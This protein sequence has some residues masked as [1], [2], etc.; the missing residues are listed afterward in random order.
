MKQED[1][2]GFI[3]LILAVAILI[4][5]VIVGINYAKEFMNKESVKDLQA[6]L[7]LIQNKVEILKGNNDMNSDENPLRGYQ[8]SQLPEGTDIN[9]FLEK[10]VITQEE[11]EKYYLL[12]SRKF[13]ANGFKGSSK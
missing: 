9:E 6:D 5:V 11:Y 13:R 2:K 1:G 4:V 12:D 8:L 7:L 3:K 10:G